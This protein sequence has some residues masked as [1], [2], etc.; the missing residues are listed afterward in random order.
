MIDNGKM[1]AYI[2]IT[3]NDKEDIRNI[4]LSKYIVQYADDYLDG[5]KEEMSGNFDICDE[6]ITK[7]VT[8]NKK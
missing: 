8:K 1:V 5:I 3:I 2:I 4:P 7:K 6:K